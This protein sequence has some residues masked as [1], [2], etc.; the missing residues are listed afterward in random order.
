MIGLNFLKVTFIEL[1]VWLFKHNGRFILNVHIVSLEGSLSLALL[2]VLELFFVL[3]L[4]FVFGITS[5]VLLDFLVIFLVFVV[6]VLFKIILF[7]LSI[8]LFSL[9]KSFVFFHIVFF[10]QVILAFI[11][12]FLTG[13]HI[14]LTLFHIV[15]SLFH[16]VL[17]LVHV[18]VSL[19]RVILS[20]FHVILSLLKV[21]LLIFLVWV[22]LVL[23]LLFHTMFTI[24]LWSLMTLLDRLVKLLC[25]VLYLGLVTKL[26][27]LGDN[28]HWLHLFFDEF[29]FVFQLIELVLS[30]LFVII[31]YFIL[32]LLISC[33]FTKGLGFYVVIF[34]EI[35]YISGLNSFIWVQ[36]T[37]RLVICGFWV[38]VSVANAFCV[39]LNFFQLE[40]F[41][42]FGSWSYNLLKEVVFVLRLII[43]L[44]LE[45][46]CLSSWFWVCGT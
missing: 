29:L 14:F 8:V 26:R 41:L 9:S 4:V 27:T 43:V 20:F 13:F 38:W 11:H 21:V 19:V 42:L 32:L 24:P 25:F 7:W 30:I 35:N 12:V 10:L 45:E 22:Y 37:L 46:I 23:V 2:E 17:T 34:L 44:W 31:D 40:I 16:I 6:L 33:N 28:V 15:L 36:N 39:C 1:G 5:V 18:V 3:A